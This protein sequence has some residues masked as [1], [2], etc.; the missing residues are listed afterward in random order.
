VV[1]VELRERR[2]KRTPLFWG[3]L[4][5]GC[6]LLWEQLGLHGLVVFEKTILL[7]G[8]L[9]ILLAVAVI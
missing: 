4:C 3:G 5:K 6:G 8:V 1:F 7:R 9:A 2:H